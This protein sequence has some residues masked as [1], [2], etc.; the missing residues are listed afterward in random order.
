MLSGSGYSIST[1]NGSTASFNTID[2]SQTSGQN[3]FDVPITLAAATT[4]TVE[5]SG[6]TLV[7]GGVISGGSTLTTGGSGTLN[8]T[9][10]NSYT[11]AT[12]VGSGTLLVDGTQPSSAVTVNSGATL[13]GIGT[14]G[15]INAT[16]AI[17]SP[18]D[19]APGI[20]IDSGSA[21]LGPDISA[22]NS[23]FTV[24]LDGT[25][26]GNGTGN[27]SQLQAGG[28][29]DLS[30]VTLNATLGS[31]FVP[32][33]G[34]TYMIIDNTGSTGIEGMFAGHAPGSTVMI[35]GT[36]FQISYT[37]GTN[38]NSVVL[39]AL[40]ASTTMLTFTPAAPVYGESV[41]LTATVSGPSGST[42]TP[43]GTVQFYNGTTLLSTD[44]L[45]GGTFTLDTTALP[46]ATNSIT[47]VYSGDT[48]YGS[49]T[50]M[51]A[52]VTVTQASTTTTLTPSTTS[53]VFG[54]DVTLTATVVPVSPGAGTPTGT[55]EFLNGTTVLG[56]E[57]LSLGTASFNTTSL[58]TGGNSITAK[59]SGDT[60]F[61][62]STSTASTVT[63]A[64]AST[65]TAVTVFPTSPVVGESVAL[66]ATV[67]PVSPGAGTPTGTVTFFSNGTSLGT[68]TLSAGVAT[69]NTTSLTVGANA[70]TADYATD[71]NFASS[72]SPAVNVTVASSANTTTTVTFAPSAP[73][74]GQSVTLTATVAAVG[75]GAS[76]PTGTVQFFNGTTL[77]G[78]ETLSSG[79]A[80][81]NTTTLPVATNSIKA[82]YSGGSPYTSSISPAVNVPV[83]LASSAT[84][85]TV[86]PVS[87]VSGQS[88]TLTATVAAVSPGV[89]TPTG[90]VTFF[91]NGTLL[92]TG[93]LSA[94]VA[95]LNT[96]ALTL[97]ANAITAQYG[98]DT[99]FS[100]S[101]SPAVSVTV[102]ATATTT[103][104][105]TFSPSTPVFGQSVTL[106]A[107]VA[108][109]TTGTPTGTVDFYNG[110]TL[111]GTGT[112]TS[113]VA[114]FDTTTLPVSSTNSITAVYSG[115]STFTSSVSAAVTVPVTQAS[116]STTVTFLPVSPIY[117][118]AVTLTA[119]IAAI[120]PGAG[121]P[122][123]SVEFLNGTTDLGSG[124]I[125]NGVATLATSVLPVGT[126]SI[127]AM[128]SGDTNFAAN[129]SPAVS[130]TVAAAATS[131]TTITFSPTSPVWGEAVTLTAT[132]AAIS[133]ATGTP[134]GT[135]QFYNGTTLLGTETLSS[136]V[137]TLS[138]TAL[139]VASNSI[140]AVYSGDSTFTSSVAPA[141]VVAV[142][143]A[144]TTTAVTFSPVAP[145]FG[146]SVTLT[147]DV[148]AVSPGAGTPTGTVEFLSGTTDLGTSTLSAG[149][150][151]FTTSPLP[152][153]SDSITAT[154]SG[155]TNFTTSTSTP[156]TVTVAQASTT[157]T[158]TSSNTSPLPFE[159]VTL[160]ATVAAVSPGAGTPTGTV[161]FLAN[162]SVIGTATI[163]AGQATFSTVAQ[164][165]IFSITAQYSGDTNFATSTSSAITATVGTAN[166]QYISAVYMIELDRAPTASDLTYWN[167]QFA[168]GR[169]RKQIVLQIATSKEAKL[170]LVQSVFL[171]YL[172]QDGTPAQVYY[173]VATAASTHT[174]VRAVVL[175][176]R[177]FYQASGGTPSSYL[178]ALETAVLGYAPYAPKL[179]EQ[180]AN[181]V[182]PVTIANELLMTNV[183][184]SVLLTSSFENVLGRAPT[185]PE[186][187]TYVT[188]MDQGVYLRQIVASLLAGNEFY[189]EVTTASS[190]S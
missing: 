177:A 35:S 136:G 182:S 65:T 122:T 155:D 74:A 151:T 25:S 3:T 146:Q 115:D 190:S 95:T 71:G 68:G 73:V 59:Y 82:V 109:T 11:G 44:T 125:A 99:D 112:L 141:V 29:I 150:A 124:T 121:M 180:L 186:S 5:N 20:L 147:A 66:T 21:T 92:G 85:T 76:T 2:W 51:V 162:G 139:P 176:S 184:K 17:V 188:L 165:G 47:A 142:A 91:S 22:N 97:G 107:T 69:L 119:T 135:V 1:N 138:T 159:T 39:T 172:G 60:N 87:P 14:V 30:G 88:V 140:T 23:T 132:V 89:G 18:G 98:G 127:T 15:G 40:A 31:G 104:T 175:G 118:Q 131:S 128:Y 61:D 145:V 4:I 19:S 134:T 10:N 55:V 96:T 143:Q 108:S 158:L 154:Y 169:T 72:T 42:V 178:A 167:K 32:T 144:S 110:T 24:E 81:L 43:S 26:A 148:V 181:G 77:L 123:G 101:T 179:G 126:N 166:E 137:A 94:G 64:A 171:Q 111:L 53:P 70:I 157:T 78:T 9:A 120:S 46:A 100:S 48:N 27:Y 106:T 63:V 58:P 52:S 174:S 84:T 185:T 38:L 113:G 12:T 163:T 164:I 6:A 13:G 45:S 116:A 90:T 54:Q 36:P 16:G 153:G 117:G 7:L 67:T 28:T 168:D 189:K 130:I 57:P 41:A 8:L 114:T 129:T 160:T 170:T 161:E 102:A 50:S 183:A 80:T 86:F 34:S 93:T 62:T 103:T 75:P 156:V 149:V 33:V 133:P 37:G 173:A 56:T 187:A 105:A 152:T 83:T 79:V 49:S